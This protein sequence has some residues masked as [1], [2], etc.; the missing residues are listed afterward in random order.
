MSIISGPNFDYTYYI[1][2][3]GVVGSLVNFLAVFLYQKFLSGWRYRKVL[4]LMKVTCCLA[5]VIDLI[6]F[7]RW[8][9]AIGIPDKIFFLFGNTIFENLVIIMLAIPISSINAKIA[10]PGMESAVFGEPISSV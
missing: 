9:I 1:T 5:S 3:T 7:K 6:I 4:I 8:N 2:V 10:P